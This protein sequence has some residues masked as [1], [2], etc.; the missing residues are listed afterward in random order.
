LPVEKRIGQFWSEKNAGGDIQ[1]DID[2]LLKLH[3]IALGLS[4]LLAIQQMISFKVEV[5]KKKTD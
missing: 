4:L 2:T 5:P 3:F 1:D